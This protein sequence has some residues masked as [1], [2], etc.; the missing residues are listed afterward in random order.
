[1]V[2]ILEPDVPVRPEPHAPLP[3]EQKVYPAWSPRL[4]S[5]ELLDP[6]SR[7]LMG[8]RWPELPVAG[9]PTVQKRAALL[10]W[11]WTDSKSEVLA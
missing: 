1:M 10:E 9:A 4:R 3:P 8:L 6:R 2:E 11:E 5:C 7:E